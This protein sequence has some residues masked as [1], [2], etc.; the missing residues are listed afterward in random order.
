MTEDAAGSSGPGVAR[1]VSLARAGSEEV[2]DRLR[3]WWDLDAETYER[4]PGHAMADPVEAA[5]WRSALR[6][7]LPPPGARVLDAGAGTGAL[8]LLAA[9][10][11][12]R[13]TALDFSS[14]MLAMAE[15]KAHA[16]G[17]DVEFV[18]GSVL[19]PPPGPFDAVMERHVLWTL[20]DPVEALRRWRAVTPG[21][22]VALY[23]VLNAPRTLT[24][25]LRDIA[26]EAAERHL[27]H[28]QDH[29]AEY[30]PDVVPLL[31][32][33]GA[34][35][36]APFVDALARGG[37][38]RYRLER[39]RDVEWARRLSEPWPLGLLKAVPRFALVA[40]A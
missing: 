34:S 17:L 23:E 3:G 11:G 9:E 18:V 5:A 33:A 6:R 7:H 4:S 1:D 14:A 37:W 29:H 10:L 2:E 28:G 26:V 20:P 15:E 12:Y 25:R 22:R 24:R 36:P 31:P 38:R 21:G 39:L 30:D 32:L 13:V 16:W 35:S 8:S 27:G 19:Q 40:D